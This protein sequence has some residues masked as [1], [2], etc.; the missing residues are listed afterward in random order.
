M[1]CS[2]VEEITPQTFTVA[3]T[4]AE[5]NLDQAG[6]EE[7]PDLAS[8]D[9]RSSSGIATRSVTPVHS[10]PATHDAASLDSTDAK[11]SQAAAPRKPVPMPTH[12][13]ETRAQHGIFKPHPR[14][15]QLA[16]LDSN[17]GDEILQ[18]ITTEEPGSVEEALSVP[19]WKE[20]ME[21]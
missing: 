7:G 19:A 13:M 2:D 3:Y 5:D 18:H 8:L 12:K 11:G 17:D 6:V 10:P 1:R 21:A 20:A 4:M 14:Y 9:L 15:A 16:M